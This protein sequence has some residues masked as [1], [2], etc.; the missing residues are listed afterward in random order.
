MTIRNQL[1]QLLNELS[2]EGLKQVLEFTEFLNG[3]DERE[4]WH[5][6]GLQQAARFYEGDESNYTLD[7]IIEDADS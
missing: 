4:A 5:E 6:F 3:K 2:E 1:D 7:D